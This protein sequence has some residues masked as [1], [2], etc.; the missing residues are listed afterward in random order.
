MC[1]ANESIFVQSELQNALCCTVFLCAPCPFFYALEQRTHIR[2][3]NGFIVWE[4]SY[5]RLI[6]NCCKATDSNSL[7]A[8]G[9]QAP[10]NKTADMENGNILKY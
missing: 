4:Q 8:T 9:V 3:T 10:I 6:R 2:G 7:I 1:E 5:V